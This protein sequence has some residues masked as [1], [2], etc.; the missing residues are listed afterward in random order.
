MPLP[1][2]DSNTLLSAWCPRFFVR[3]IR[4][5][6][7]DDQHRMAVASESLSFSNGS[8]LSHLH[9]EIDRLAIYEPS[10]RYLILPLDAG[11]VG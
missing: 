7:Q 9:L 1:T 6:H 5:L 2:A 8:N 4:S 11:E 10:R 3:R